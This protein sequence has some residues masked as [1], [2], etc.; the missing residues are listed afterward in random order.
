MANGKFVAYYR[1]STQQQGSS[2]LGLEAQRNAVAQY[3]NGGNWS[4]IGEFTEIESGTGKRARP[5]LAEALTMCKK[6]KAVL[7][8][9]KLDRLARNVAFVANL[10]EAGVRFICVD[11]PDADRAFLQMGAVFGEWEARKISE[12]T[13]AAL[14]AA[15]ARGTR[16]GNP[17][18]LSEAGELGRAQAASRAAQRAGNVLPIIRQVQAG[19]VTTLEGIANALNLRGIKAARG[20]EWSATQVRR[21]LVHADRNV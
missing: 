1:V 3:L 8:I 11:Q 21:L 15:K 18:N 4:L 9:A 13:K 12:R 7:L 2:G 6:Q 17:V 20:G 16:L 5:K 19:G 10:L 14:Q